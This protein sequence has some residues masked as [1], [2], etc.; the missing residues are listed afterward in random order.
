MWS[1]A[2]DLLPK[3]EIVLHAKQLILANIYE[4]NVFYQSMIISDSS[5][6]NDNTETEKHF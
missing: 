2:N 4:Q 6:I 1:D 5:D 3:L